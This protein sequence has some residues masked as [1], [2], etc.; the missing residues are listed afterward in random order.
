MQKKNVKGCFKASRMVFGCSWLPCTS[1]TVESQVGMFFATP[2]GCYSKGTCVSMGCK[3][4]NRSGAFAGLSPF[5]RD[6]DLGAQLSLSA[7]A[8]ELMR[9]HPVAAAT[10]MGRAGYFPCSSKSGSAAGC[11]AVQFWL[12]P[13]FCSYE[14]FAFQL[15]L[16]GVNE[17]SSPCPGAGTSLGCL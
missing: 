8:A 12:P 14:V 13:C 5:L 7:R 10:A 9:P 15:G 6:R 2:C 17:M 16:C 11:Q 3:Y 1:Q 4:L